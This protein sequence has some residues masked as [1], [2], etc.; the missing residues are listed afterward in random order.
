V[1]QAAN[2]AGLLALP[3]D[4]AVCRMGR[5]L[6]EAAGAAAQRLQ[7]DT[8][9]EALHDFRVALRRLRSNLGIYRPALAAPV[10]RKRLRQVAALARITNEARDSE[11]EIQWL[12]TVRGRIRP[13]ER[14]GCDWLL[15]ALQER[16]RAAYRDI[17]DYD[18]PRRFRRLNL[19]LGR[20]LQQGATAHGPPFARVLAASL[21]EAC[22]TLEVRLQRLQSSP[23]ESDA[24]QAR[25]AG[26]RVRYILEPVREDLPGA[27]T[28]VGRLKA[29]QDLLGAIHDCQVMEGDLMD[30]AAAAAAEKARRLMELT[31]TGEG[32]T[33]AAERRQ[34]YRAG[35]LA[36]GGLLRERRE[37]LFRQLTGVLAA[38]ET[39]DAVGTVRVLADRLAASG[40]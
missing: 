9:P 15:H 37:A 13:H 6:L 40:R 10:P 7:G 5:A 3:V 29:L 32:G 31:L 18:V 28:A 21:H 11:V 17:D 2:T 20:A 25:I 30:L 23:D 38:V 27:G 34:G 35:L 1:K 33:G 19:K 36:V 8:D 4:L 24:H 22:D 14:P 26:K 12:G 39:P 16:A